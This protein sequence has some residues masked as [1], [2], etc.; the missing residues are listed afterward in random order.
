MGRHP[1]RARGAGT[2]LA[3]ALLPLAVLALAGVASACSQGYYDGS[4]YVRAQLIKAL[5]DGDRRLRV[6][7]T[8]SAEAA[9]EGRASL[10]VSV[11]GPKETRDSKAAA[12]AALLGAIASEL[13]P[14]DGGPGAGGGPGPAAI[15][16]AVSVT[17]GGADDGAAGGGGGGGGG[18]AKPWALEPVATVQA[19]FGGN[20]FFIKSVDWKRPEESCGHRPDGA[21]AFFT[22]DGVSSPCAASAPSGLPDELGPDCARLAAD[23]A[24][25]AFGLARSGVVA[26]TGR[27]GDRRAGL[28]R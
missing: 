24:E 19:A 16:V 26:V 13:S 5:L 27:P 11:R 10:N 6:D 20:R 8:D 12:L 18:G 21:Y 25:A 9:R 7:L 22:P 3:A 4:T 23:A 15:K 17:S 28:R 1:A 14:P 2:R